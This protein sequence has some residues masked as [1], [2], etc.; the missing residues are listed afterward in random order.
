MARKTVDPWNSNLYTP[1]IL[2]L[3]KPTIEAFSHKKG[4][5]WAKAI[6]EKHIRKKIIQ[7]GIKNT[8]GREISQ[9][10][11][12]QLLRKMEEHSM[13]VRDEK[14]T[15]YGKRYSLL[16]P[17]LFVENF[18]SIF[19]TE[20]KEELKKS[21]KNLESLKK[22]EM[23]EEDT[24]YYEKERDVFSYKIEIS[25]EV[26][27]HKKSPP[28]IDMLFTSLKTVLNRKYYWKL[29]IN[30]IFRCIIDAIGTAP[31]QYSAL[32]QP[33]V[34]KSIQ[35]K[36]SPIDC[37]EDL[38]FIQFLMKLQYYCKI[39]TRRTDFFPKARVVIEDALGLEIPY[40]PYQV[41]K[42]AQSEFQ[43]S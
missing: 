3:I 34:K 6:N 35:N 5:R 31:L 30:E 43:D 25:K 18:L 39:K 13:I 4:D 37:L 20:F 23:N 36:V 32:I 9:P 10:R 22:Y 29:S 14:K 33:F 7:L 24:F 41:A 21:L 40:L 11:L 2:A 8:R 28:I 27:L 15:Q 16:N 1:I 26:E 12:N 38:D 17:Y 42:Q 19:F